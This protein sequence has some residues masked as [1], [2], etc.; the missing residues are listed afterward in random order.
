MIEMT[1]IAV[2]FILPRGQTLKVSTFFRY[3]TFNT[4]L[5]LH[6]VYFQTIRSILNPFTA[7]VL[8]GVFNAALAFESVDEIL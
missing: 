3:N 7:G 1:V 5:V 2:N 8:D 4:L 6:V